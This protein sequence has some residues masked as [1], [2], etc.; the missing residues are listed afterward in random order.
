MA[1]FSHAFKVNDSEVNPSPR[2]DYCNAVLSTLFDNTSQHG[3]KTGSPTIIP[4]FSHV[5]TLTCASLPTLYITVSPGLITGLVL[6]SDIVC[7]RLYCF[8]LHFCLI[9]FTTQIPYML[10]FV[11]ELWLSLIHLCTFGTT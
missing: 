3:I 10:A 8:A 1:K 9:V 7:S 5:Q 6:S 11:K 2:L 4:K